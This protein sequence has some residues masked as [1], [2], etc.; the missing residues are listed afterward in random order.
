MLGIKHNG[1]LKQ[2]YAYMNFLRYGTVTETSVTGSTKL[3]T[4]ASQ[5]YRDT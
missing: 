3:L 4:T 2:L 1:A 5:W